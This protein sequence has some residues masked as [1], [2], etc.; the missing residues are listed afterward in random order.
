MADAVMRSLALGM[1]AAVLSGCAMLPSLGEAEQQAFGKSAKT[2]PIVGPSGELMGEA[3]TR[4]EDKLRTLPSANLERKLVLTNAYTGTPLTAGNGTKI[5]L[6]GPNAYESMFDAIEGARDHVHLESYIFDDVETSRRLSDLLTRKAREG[7]QV[8]VIY[9]SVGSRK[10]P[11]SFLA[12]LEQAGVTL[13][14]FNPVNPL[15]ARLLFIN[16]RDHRKILVVDGKVAFTGGINFDGVYMSGSGLGSRKMPTLD[17]GWRDTHLR[18]EGPAVPE[19]QKLFLSTWEKQNCRALEARNPYPTQAARGDMVV[20]VIGSS[21]DGKMSSMYLTLIAAFAYAERSI[22]LSVAYFV[23]DPNTLMALK[24]AAARGVD[25]KVLLPGFTDSWLAFHAGRS[26]YEELLEAGV[27]LY[28]YQGGVFHA[29]TAV[30]DG[31]WST[32]GSSNVDWRSFCY[33]D[34]VNAVVVGQGFAAE[35]ERVF[36]SDLREAAE[37]T[38]E[39]W[40]GRDAYARMSEYTARWFEQQ[41]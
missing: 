14:E 1:V 8:R 13:C 39:R 18:L 2:I 9:D 32:I 28:E 16:N 5:L 3:R 25:V 29:K 20:S 33:N 23:P 22:H 19:L 31:V 24:A 15:R 36:D 35:M 37:V 6:D 40:A 17:D 10:T 41:L 26:F 12:S 21:P 38:R 4:I 11:A 30:V 7:V 27:K 34:E